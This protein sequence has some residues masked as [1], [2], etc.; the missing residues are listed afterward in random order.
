MRSWN[1][2][3]ASPIEQAY[4]ERLAKIYT[5]Y[6]IGVVRY[7]TNTW[8]LW[9]E[10]LVAYYIDRRYHFGVVV[11]S[12]IEGCHAILKSYLQRGH[13]TLADVF[14]KLIHFWADQH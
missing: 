1:A 13:G 6:P 2:L 7:C 4:Q 12:L 10:S 14:S 8:L 11:T 9:K 3:V 5:I